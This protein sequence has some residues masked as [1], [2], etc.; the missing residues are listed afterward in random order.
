MSNIFGSAFDSL[1]DLA[2]KA[3][4]ALNSDNLSNIGNYATQALKKVSNIQI[5]D[6]AGVIFNLDKANRPLPSVDNKGQ[7]EGTHESY[8]VKL[9]ISGAK[10]DVFGATDFVISAYLPENYSLQFGSSWATPLDKTIGEAIAGIPPANGKGT[11]SKIVNGVRKVAPILNIATMIAGGANRFKLQTAHIWQNG[12][13][14]SLSIPFHFAA[15]TNTYDDVIRHFRTLSMLASPTEAF[16]IL[17]PPGPTLLGAAETLIKANLGEI[18]GT[19]AFDGLKG[20]EGT[21][22]SIQL[23][24]FAYIEPIIIESVDSTIDTIND[25]DG[26]PMFMAINVNIKS[27][28]TMSAND[29]DKMINHPILKGRPDNSR[30]PISRS[31]EDQPL[32][33]DDDQARYFNGIQNIVTDTNAKGDYNG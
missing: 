2:D 1:S 12:Q 31:Q 26:K 30:K 32:L 5:G 20:L 21:K 19:S 17:Y 18:K 24:Q 33:N 11:G 10:G 22:I 23:G 6:V 27:Y 16:G 4:D 25:E 15:N 14:L 3:S 13:P 8:I 28:Y 29:I 9:I 7:L